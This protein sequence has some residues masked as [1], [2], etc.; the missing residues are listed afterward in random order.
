MFF[1][2]EK[3]NVLSE[4]SSSFGKHLFIPA[5]YIWATSWAR[6]RAGCLRVQVDAGLVEGQCSTQRGT[7]WI[8]EGRFFF[9]VRLETH[10]MPA[11]GYAI[12]F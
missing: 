10:F 7:L 3:K 11:C 8:L 5:V 9:G 1:R 4:F 2:T 6:P 12:Y